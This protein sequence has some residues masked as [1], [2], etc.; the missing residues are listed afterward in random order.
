MNEIKKSIIQNLQEMVAL[1]SEAVLALSDSLQSFEFEKK[2]LILQKGN[3]CDKIYFLAEGAVR[4]FILDK[5]QNEISVWF[6]FEGDVVASLSSMVN[7]KGSHTGFQALERCSGFYI[8]YEDLN[9]L[10]SKFHSIERL[11]RVVTEH[12]LL[13][14]ESYHYDFHYLTAIE[15][16]EKLQSEK[17]WIFNR[18]SLHQIASYLGV[19]KETLSRIRAKKT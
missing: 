2:E 14:T 15:R 19:S 11:G 3:V 5:K 7:Q 17:M 4:E 8:N 12:Y 13:S 9:N 16:F 6:G 10:Y 18:V 1:E